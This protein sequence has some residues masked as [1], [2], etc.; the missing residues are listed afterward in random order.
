[1]E[2]AARVRCLS[3]HPDI[4]QSLDLTT[5]MASID[6][7]KDEEETKLPTYEQ[8]YPDNWAGDKVVEGIHKEA[9]LKILSWPRDENNKVKKILDFHFSFVLSLLLPKNIIRI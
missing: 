4:V 7:S 8:M 5:L 9:V 6:L 3:T 2:S 1:M